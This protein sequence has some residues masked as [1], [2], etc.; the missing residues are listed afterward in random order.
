MELLAIDNE[1]YEV[2]FSSADDYYHANNEGRW[3]IL[4]HYLIVNEWHPNSDPFYDTTADAGLGTN[5]VP[6][7]G[8][9]QRGVPHE[10]W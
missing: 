4:D 1:Y 8:T 2:K 10:G 9:L 5:F 7:L 3:M 6:P